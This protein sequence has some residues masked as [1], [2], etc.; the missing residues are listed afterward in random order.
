MLNAQLEVARKLIPHFD[1]IGFM[2]GK[3]KQLT[4]SIWV[5][6]RPDGTV[7]P[8]TM[9]DTENGCTMLALHN[10]QAVKL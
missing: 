5:W 4:P 8:G 10:P 1:N 3:A 7:I 6:E 9:A 2:R